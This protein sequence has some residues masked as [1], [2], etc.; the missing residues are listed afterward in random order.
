[1]VPAARAEVAQEP[2]AADSLSVPDSLAEA[3]EEVILSDVRIAS[4]QLSVP[5]LGA[6]SSL[7]E[8]RTLT[9]EQWENPMHFQGYRWDG[10]QLLVYGVNLDE[11][12]LSYREG[13]L[14]LRCRGQELALKET[15]AFVRFPA[16]FLHASHEE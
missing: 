10:Q 3:E 2:V 5:V 12:D 7:T 14:L 9:V 15:A 1:P 8:Q 13:R 11:L 16:A 6:D 4:V